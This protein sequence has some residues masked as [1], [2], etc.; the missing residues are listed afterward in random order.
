MWSFELPGRTALGSFRRKNRTAR[1][2]FVI[3]RRNNCDKTCKNSAPC[4]GHIVPGTQIC[5]ACLFVSIA[6]H[7]KGVG[8]TNITGTYGAMGRRIRFTILVRVTRQARAR[9]GQ[10]FAFRNISYC[11]LWGFY[12]YINHPQYQKFVTQLSA[13]FYINTDIDG[14]LGVTHIGS[15]DLRFGKQA[16]AY[17]T[18]ALELAGQACYI[19]NVGRRCQ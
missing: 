7:L 5:V 12:I 2:K 6:F 10:Y 19:T 14:P 1:R 16:S 4:V 17:S 18:K 8:P 13:F 9:E 15:G 3:I 11:Y